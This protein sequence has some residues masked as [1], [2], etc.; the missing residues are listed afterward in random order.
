MGLGIQWQKECWIHLQHPYWLT[1]KLLFVP[2]TQ[3][4]QR[5]HH[6]ITIDQQATAIA[7]VGKIFFGL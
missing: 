1:G 5:E 6:K 7:S 4:S 3:T 2:V